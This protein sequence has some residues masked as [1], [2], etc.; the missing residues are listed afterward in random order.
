MVKTFYACI[1]DY[2]FLCPHCGVV[3]IDIERHQDWHKLTGTLT[4]KREI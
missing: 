1:G 4:L 2:E 3:V